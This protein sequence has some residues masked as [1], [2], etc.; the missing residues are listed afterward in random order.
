MKNIID[1]NLYTENNTN[2]CNN[3]LRLIKINIENRDYEMLIKIL[4]KTLKNNCLINNTYILNYTLFQLFI[5]SLDMYSDHKIK[6]IENIIDLFIDNGATDKM[7]TF[8]NTPLTDL[9]KQ[10]K[11]HIVEYIINKHRDYKFNNKT[12]WEVIYEIP[13]NKRKIVLD[14][15]KKSNH[16]DFYLKNHF[17]KYYFNLLPIDIQEHYPNIKRNIDK[18]T[19]TNKFNL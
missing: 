17:N 15:L 10:Q 14:I 11:F 13:N 19:K 1:Y 8:H 4:T 2:K 6:F 12:I 3:F 18:I 7:N 16:F 5:R 9:I